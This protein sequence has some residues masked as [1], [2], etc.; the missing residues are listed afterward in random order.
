MKLCG[1][2]FSC[3][4]DG[5]SSPVTIYFTPQ[6][7]PPDPAESFRGTP[8]HSIVDT[9]LLPTDYDYD[10]TLTLDRAAGSR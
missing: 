6:A 7:R 4:N 1:N 10:G 9:S 3:T 2:N 5:H 8:G